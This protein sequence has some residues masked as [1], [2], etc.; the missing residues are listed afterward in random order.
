MAV[1]IKK[2]VDICLSSGTRPYTVVD[3]F[4]TSLTFLQSEVTDKENQIEI[5][6]IRRALEQLEGEPTEIVDIY[7][8]IITLY[9]EKLFNP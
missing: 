8:Q 6:K 9:I 5:K 1:I 3:S 4:K 2:L 7:Y